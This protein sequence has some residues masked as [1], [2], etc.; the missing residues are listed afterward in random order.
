[1]LSAAQ[2]S[3]G[4]QCLFAVGCSSCLLKKEVGGESLELKNR[5]SEETPGSTVLCPSK[6]FP[7]R[8]HAAASLIG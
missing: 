6:D 2:A 1:M 4:K 7:N 3:F 8:D 5:D